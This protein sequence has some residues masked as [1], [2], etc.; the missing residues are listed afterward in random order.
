LI[1][2]NGNRN[3][4]GLVSKTDYWDKTAILRRKWVR[5]ASTIQACA[6]VQLKYSKIIQIIHQSCP[7]VPDMWTEDNRTTK[8]TIH[9]PKILNHIPLFH[10]VNLLQVNVL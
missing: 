9:W 1:L 5:L 7:L 2:V 3:L 4:A 6:Q 8:L 10:L